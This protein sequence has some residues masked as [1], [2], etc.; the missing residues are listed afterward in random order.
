MRLSVKEIVQKLKLLHEYNVQTTL[1]LI[2]HLK[3][4]KALGVILRIVIKGLGELIYYTSF[5]F[6][7]LRAKTDG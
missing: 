1:L 5:F 2:S 4:L 7:M 3:I 6:L